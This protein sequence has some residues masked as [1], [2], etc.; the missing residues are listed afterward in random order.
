MAMPHGSQMHPGSTGMYTP[1]GP[2]NGSRMYDA[3]P[4]RGPS[5][6]S[7]RPPVPPHPDLPMDDIQRSHISMPHPGDDGE[8]P[9]LY[10]RLMPS[11][12]P[13]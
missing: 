6:Y 4:G 11:A 3:E 13:P 5:M 12:H 8:I 9:N 1:H 2:P 10:S 7:T